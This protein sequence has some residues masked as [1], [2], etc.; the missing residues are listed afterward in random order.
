MKH[1]TASL[2][3]AT[4]GPVQTL[5]SLINEFARMGEVRDS[6]NPRAISYTLKP[7]FVRS[8]ATSGYPFLTFY[9]FNDL[10]G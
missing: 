1:F 10:A 5:Q 4:Q 7:A 8:F 9:E 2:W 6:R 3:K